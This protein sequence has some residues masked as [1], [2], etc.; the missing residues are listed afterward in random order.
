M[1]YRL[2]SH[3][4]NY[5]AAI[6]GDIK[7]ALSDAELLARCTEAHRIR[8]QAR[9]LPLSSI[10]YRAWLDRS[11]A[12]LKALPPRELHKQ[13]DKLRTQISE[14]S[15]TL[16]AGYRQRADDI[17]KRNPQPDDEALAVAEKVVASSRRNRVADIL[18]KTAT[19]RQ[20]S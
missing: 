2:P 6:P 12:V 5:A 20:G 8:E 18:Y 15:G 7:K 10:D 17:A 9:T 1:P 4:E 3:L 11:T 16:R 13:L 19:R 14:S